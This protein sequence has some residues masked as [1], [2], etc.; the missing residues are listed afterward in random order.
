MPVNPHLEEAMELG[1]VAEA[2]FDLEGA[3]AAYMSIVEKYGTDPDSLARVAVAGERTVNLLLQRGRFA[4]AGKAAEL[5]AR[6]V[7]PTP[8]ALVTQHVGRSLVQGAEAWKLADQ[9]A[10]AME[11]Y[12]CALSL[13]RVLRASDLE[14]WVSA[15]ALGRAEGFADS[16]QPG[17]AARVMRWLQLALFLGQD[18]ES[19]PIKRIARVLEAKYL[20]IGVADESAATLTG[21]A[22]AVVGEWRSG[23]RLPDSGQVRALLV[24]AR[25]VPSWR[26]RTALAQGSQSAEDHQDSP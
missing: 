18:Q 26:R 15:A 13:V 8:D 25:I 14:D 6:T 11:C 12:E 1:E 2:R 5:L 3:T 20:L 22:S 24:A 21:V 17:N 7:A 4:E 9:P 23:Q 10:R 19:R 16:G